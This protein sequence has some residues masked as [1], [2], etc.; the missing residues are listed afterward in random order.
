MPNQEIDLATFDF[1]AVHTETVKKDTPI[2][3]DVPANMVALAQKSWDNQE[4]VTMTFRGQSPAFVT[5]FAE[6]MKAAGD[7]TTPLT[8]VNVTHEANSIIVSFV[9]QVRR[10]APKGSKRNGAGK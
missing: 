6:T 8:T 7:H 1:D 2:I 4:R 10:G 3:R 9:A 5:K